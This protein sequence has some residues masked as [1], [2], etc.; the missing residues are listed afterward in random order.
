M[1]TYSCFPN[2]SFRMKLRNY[3]YLLLPQC[4][5]A[6][7]C[8]TVITAIQTSSWTSVLEPMC[9]LL[10]AYHTHPK[11]Y[12]RPSGYF[13]SMFFEK[14]L[15]KQKRKLS[16]Q[17][18]NA[19]W[20]LPL[21]FRFLYRCESALRLGPLY[22]HDTP[23][24]YNFHEG[25]C[26]RHPSFGNPSPSTTSMHIFRSLCSKLNRKSPPKVLLLKPTKKE[27]CVC[28]LYLYTFKHHSPDKE[29]P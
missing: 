21:S 29:I 7:V 27:V 12:P 19:N 10:C 20:Q 1:E 11:P 22:T 6:C 26:A 16:T 8:H 28:E 2:S 25:P 13:P 3:K 9:W 23:Q 17:V 24:N 14:N 15:S 4:S 18:S 5:H